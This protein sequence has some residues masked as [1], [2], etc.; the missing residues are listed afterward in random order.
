MLYQIETVPMPVLHKNKQAQ[1][2][3]Q[4]KVYKPYIAL[5]DETCISLLPQEL[6]MCK[7]I[8]Y[9]FFCEELFV[10]KSKNKYSC[11]SAIYFNLNLD[12]VRKNCEFTFYFNKTDLKPSV[13]DGGHQIILVDW[14]NYKRIICTHNNNIPVNIPSHPYVLLNR[15]ILC[16]C[17]IEAECNFLLESLMACKENNKPDLEMYFTVNLAFVNYLDLLNE[18]IE[19]PIVRN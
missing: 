1:T 17:D 9:E 10:V 6:N 3:N 13:L 7:R 12:D 15:S 2:Y 5:N 8:G 4:L 16:N 18:T 14:P 19:I 11:A